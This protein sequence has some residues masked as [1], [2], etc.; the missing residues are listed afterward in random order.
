MRIDEFCIQHGG[1]TRNIRDVVR[2]WQL[3]EADAH[4]RTL[5]DQHEQFIGSA[6]IA[7]DALYGGTLL[8]QIPHEV[9][10]AFAGL[11]R[12]KAASYGEMRRI[13]LDRLRSEHGNFLSF[14]DRHVVGFISKLK[15]QIGENLF[16][17][18]VG[19]AAKLARSGIQEGWDVAVQRADGLREYVQVKLYDQPYGVVRHM[20]KVQE[21]VINGELRGVDREVVGRVFFAV[22]A[23]IREDVQRL[24]EK[25]DGLADMI[26]DKSIP[27]GSR[28]AAD[29]VTEGMSNVGPDQLSHFFDELLRG[30]IAAGSLHAIVNGFLWYKG[31]KEFSAAFADTVANTAISTTGIGL[32]LLAETLCHTTLLSGAIGISSRLFIGR[33]ARSRWNFAEFLAESIAETETRVGLLTP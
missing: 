21:K 25:H 9:K 6:V 8:D 17:Q 27:I 14:D 16:Q 24:A 23:D 20:L 32:G 22:P 28:D 2:H 7:G 31:S 30:A 5:S 26:Y 11:F 29:L 18:H 1:N 12:E 15:G 10:D 3:D 33:M 19:S 13:L 4:L